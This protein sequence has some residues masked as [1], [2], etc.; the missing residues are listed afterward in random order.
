MD[1]DGQ[2]IRAERAADVQP[3]YERLGRHTVNSC[4]VGVRNPYP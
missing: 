4:A 1:V 3:V 2:F